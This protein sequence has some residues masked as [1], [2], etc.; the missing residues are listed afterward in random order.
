V[1]ERGEFVLFIGSN[2]TE[3]WQARLKSKDISLE[4]EK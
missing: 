2:F 3:V 4:N 1:E